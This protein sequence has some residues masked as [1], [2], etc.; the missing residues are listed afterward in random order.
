MKVMYTLSAQDVDQVFIGWSCIQCHHCI[1]TDQYPQ[2]IAA[3]TI[4]PSLQLTGDAVHKVFK[5]IST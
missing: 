2:M 4:L 1:I 5:R 3:Q